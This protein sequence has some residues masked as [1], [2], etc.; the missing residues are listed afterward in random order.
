MSGRHHVVAVVGGATAGA[1]AARIF[2]EQG[3]TTF[4]IEQHARPY[5][6]VEDGLPRW[7]VKLRQREFRCID[8]KLDRPGIHYLPSTRLGR[9][10]PLEELLQRWHLHAVVLAVGA[11]RDRPLPIEGIDAYLGRGLVYQNAFIQWVNHKDEPGYSGVQLEIA[12]GT[13]VVGGGLASIDVAKAVQFELALSALRDRGIE[14][15]LLHLEE[16]GLPAV[17]GGHGL[18]WEELGLA[19]A[20][21]CY[22]RRLED[23][24]LAEMP[25]DPTPEQRVKA[26]T[27]RRKI[28][29]KASDKYLFRLAPLR[30]PADAIVDDDRLGGLVFTEMEHLG[31]GRVRATSNRHEMRSRLTVGSIG[32]LPLPIPGLPMN[33]ELY[34]FEDGRLGTFRDLPNVFTVGNAVTGKGNLVVSRKHATEVA[35]RLAESIAGQVSDIAAYVR[36]RTPLDDEEMAAVLA[37]ARD[38]QARVGYD[39]VYEDWMRRVSPPGLRLP[40]NPVPVAPARECGDEP[41]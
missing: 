16:E 37:A 27:V 41:A 35:A 5:G 17:L 40:R 24:A 3:I 11:W 18:R 31:E 12:D 39:G 14:E 19:G 9:D 4:V 8:D 7:H 6:K 28:V 23:M 29:Q 22:R 26:E 20:V 10:L 32:S 13:V 21:L 33:G 2:A 30:S 1:E 15:D 36:T 38:V 25:E 34:A